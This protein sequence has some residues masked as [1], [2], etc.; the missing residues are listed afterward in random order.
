MC[1]TAMYRD[2]LR[3]EKKK[4]MIQMCCIIYTIQSYCNLKTKLVFNFEVPGSMLIYQDTTDLSA[5]MRK[6]VLQAF[7]GWQCA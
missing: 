5:L 7:D 3:M 2:K 6:T 1:V 4:K